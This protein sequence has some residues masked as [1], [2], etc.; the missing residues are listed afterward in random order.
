MINK[1]ATSK[2]ATAPTMP[3]GNNTTKTANKESKANIILNGS[4]KRNIPVF[5][6]T[7]KSFK[8]ATTKITIKRTPSISI[9]QLSFISPSIYGSI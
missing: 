9:L 3:S 6:N 7:K 8:N 2:P 5:K 4:A 1:G